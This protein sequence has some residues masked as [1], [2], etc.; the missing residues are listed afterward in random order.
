MSYV[1]SLVNS[2]LKIGYHVAAV[3]AAILLVSRYESAAPREQ[4]LYLAFYSLT[5]GALGGLVWPITFCGYVDYTYR[6][7]HPPPTADG[8]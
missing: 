4:K 3:L 1:Q 6:R 7:L 8:Q 2:Y 5:Y